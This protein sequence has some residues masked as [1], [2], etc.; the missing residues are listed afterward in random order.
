[1]SSFHGRTITAPAA[2]AGTNTVP[3]TAPYTIGPDEVDEAAKAFA[4]ALEKVAP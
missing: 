2:T 1:M 3:L 4:T